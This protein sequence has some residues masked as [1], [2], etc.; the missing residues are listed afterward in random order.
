LAAKNSSSGIK[1]GIRFDV[2]PVFWRL[3]L[4]GAAPAG[5]RKRRQGWRRK[6]PDA[7]R[8]IQTVREDVEG[9][10]GHIFLQNKGEKK[11]TV[12]VVVFG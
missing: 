1:S 7:A 5:G 9:L 4:P 10:S 6:R 8:N 11:M 3:E 12:V 2:F